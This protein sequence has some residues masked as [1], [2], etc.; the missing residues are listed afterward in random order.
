[1]PDTGPDESPGRE[2]RIEIRLARLQQ[3]FNSL[4]PS[5]FHDRD[6]DQNAEEYIVESAD[7][8][9][10]P[11]P[12]TLVV[13]LPADQASTVQT[14]D[15]EQSIHNYF[16]YRLNETRR[17]LRLFFRD[18]RIALGIG[19]AFLFVCIALRQIVMAAWRGTISE[20]AEEGLL[21]VGWVAMWRP[22]EIF[23]YEW[24]PIRRRTRV[25]AKLARMPV[26]VRETRP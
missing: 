5:P 14:S 23:L 24:W 21:I 19:L 18:G 26:I 2:A 16:A 1:V 20:I 9:P 12:L 13:Y 3:L 11:T 4:D 25:F 10:L 22:L 17:R 6:L 15:L 8:F 7:E